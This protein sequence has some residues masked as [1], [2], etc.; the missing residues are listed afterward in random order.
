M[1]KFSGAET[2]SLYA[3]IEDA[4]QRIISN[5]EDENY[6]KQQQEFI[7]QCEEELESRL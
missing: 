3:L 6:V 4:R 5:P 1:N 2:E 7:N